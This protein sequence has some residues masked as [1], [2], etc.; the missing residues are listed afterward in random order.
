[1]V[2]LTFDISHRYSSR[3]LS[4]ARIDEYRYILSI[5][6]QKRTAQNDSNNPNF[7]TA[8]VPSIMSWIDIDCDRQFDN[9]IFLCQYISDSAKS[10]S[11]MPQYSDEYCKAPIP[12]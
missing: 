5:L 2:E 11:A 4:E 10:D 8:L 7:C 12:V 6:H 1:M 3:N 9:A